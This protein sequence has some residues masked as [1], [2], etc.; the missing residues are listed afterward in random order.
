MI[1]SIMSMIHVRTYL[2]DEFIFKAGSYGTSTYILLEG[3]AAV[4]GLSSDFLGIM[5][6]GCHYSN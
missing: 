1:N 6:S 3:R 5:K 2:K 4:F